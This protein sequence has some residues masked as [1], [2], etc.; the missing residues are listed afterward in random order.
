[1]SQ[2]ETL[3]KNLYEGDI[4]SYITNNEDEPHIV[5]GTDRY[6]TVPEELKRIGVEHDHNIETVI[7]DC[8]RYWDGHDLSQMK[9]YVNYMCANKA[10]GSYP[11]KTVWI[12]DL[13]DKIM[14][15]EWEITN[16]VTQA[17]GQ[18]A[19]LVCVKNTDSYGNLANHWNSELNEEM[20]ISR[21]LETIETLLDLQP[22]I[23]THVLLLSDAVLQ[24]AAVYVGPGDMP[25]GYNVQID[26]TA[27]N[28]LRVK[29][30]DGNIVDI[31]AIKGD[32]GDPGRGYNGN[33]KLIV[34]AEGTMSG[35]NPAIIE[36][37]DMFLYEKIYIYTDEGYR[38]GGLIYYGAW[39][40]RFKFN[41][42]NDKNNGT[43]NWYESYYMDPDDCVLLCSVE[44]TKKTNRELDI[45][46]GGFTLINLETNVHSRLQVDSKINTTEVPCLTLT[47]QQAYCPH[48]GVELSDVGVNYSIYA[49]ARDTSDAD[50]VEM[51]DMVLAALPK[52]TGGGY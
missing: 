12:D 20:Y 39:D 3:L 51:V 16:N 4:S 41:L 22:D 28:I 50:K 1:M 15:F 25:D 5:I 26:T 42:L 24:R 30:V 33:K 48:E 6:I 19:F 18:I 10:V 2:A 34:V 52:W 21:G 43:D 29:D 45:F 38:G 40:R 35:V 11:T 37:P 36:I 46:S 31:P 7:F 17:D 23:L 27:K 32:R 14:H 8:P 13:D 49:I 44:E 47:P 9:I